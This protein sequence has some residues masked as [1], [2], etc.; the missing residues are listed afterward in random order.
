MH[1]EEEILKRALQFIEENLFNKN[2]TVNKVADYT[3]VSVKI[4]D[5]IFAGYELPPPCRYIA[6]RRAEEAEKEIINLHRNCELIKSAYIAK[7]CGYKNMSNMN[8]SIKSV[9]EMNYKK[10]KSMVIA[11]F[12]SGKT[13]F[14]KNKLLWK[15]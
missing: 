7:K 12:T 6:L 13:P 15:F 9:T 11:N 2:L 14:I 8:Y 1:N 3:G 5:E 10:F 4:L